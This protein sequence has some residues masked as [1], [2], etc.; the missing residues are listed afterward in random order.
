VRIEIVGRNVE[1]TDELRELARKRFE[2]V[3]RQVS[4]LARLV[5]VLREEAN[6]AIRDRFHAEA[7]L[8]LKGRTVRAQESAADAFSAIRGVSHDI[9]RQVKRNRELRRK[10]ATTR[11]LVGR[12]RRKPAA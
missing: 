10:R 6:P 3:A 5:I 8:H 11:R 7:S 9:K 12:M 2:R 1:V 4:D